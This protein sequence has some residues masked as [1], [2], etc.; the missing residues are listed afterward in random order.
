MKPD[1]RAPTHH[2][3]ADRLYVKLD[4]AAS[5][6]HHHKIEHLVSFCAQATHE[7]SFHEAAG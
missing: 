3:I 1:T 2:S 6:D 7:T 4:C 5:L